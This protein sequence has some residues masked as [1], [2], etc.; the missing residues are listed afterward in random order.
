MVLPVSTTSMRRI[1]SVFSRSLAASFFTSLARSLGSSA[2][3]A[4][5]A[6]SAAATARLTSAAV[7]CG[8]W[9]SVSSVAGL[10]DSSH[11]PPSLGTSS[12]PISIMPRMRL[13]W[14]TFMFLKPLLLSKPRSLKNDLRL[15]GNPVPLRAFGPDPLGELRRR[16]ADRVEAERAQPLVD[17]RQRDDAHDLAMPAIDDVLRRV[18][19]R[20]DAGH[21]IG[22][23]IGH[24]RLRNGGHVRHVAV[25]LRRKHRKPAQLAVLDVGH[26]WG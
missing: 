24:A 18:G 8:T 4:G 2:A 10:T 23:L 3:Q 19:E 9:P 26:R 22:L 12:P 25:A 5:C 14:C 21:R 11:S 7:P 6:A 1:S 13:D 17:V 15:F 16:I 20:H